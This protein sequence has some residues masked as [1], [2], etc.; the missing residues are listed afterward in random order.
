MDL[1]HKFF[2]EVHEHINQC[3]L[4]STVKSPNLNWTIR[5]AIV[6]LQKL[7]PGSHQSLLLTEIIQAW[8]EDVYI[9]ADN[10]VRPRSRLGR[11]KRDPPLIGGILQAN[12]LGLDLMYMPDDFAKEKPVSA[13]LHLSTGETMGSLLLDS[14]HR[15]WLCKDLPCSLED[16]FGSLKPDENGHTPVISI[17]A[18]GVERNLSRGKSDLLMLRGVRSM[19]AV[20]GGDPAA[21][22]WIQTTLHRAQEGCSFIAAKLTMLEHDEFTCT[23]TARL[24]HPS[25]EAVLGHLVLTSHSSDLATLVKSSE[26]ALLWD[27]ELVPGQTDRSSSSIMDRQSQ[28][29]VPLYH[30]GE[31]T[32]CVVVEESAYSLATQQSTDQNISESRHVKVGEVQN[33]GKVYI[34]RDR[35]HTSLTLKDHR[36]STTL[37][38]I[39]GKLGSRRGNRSTTCMVTKHNIPIL[40]LLR[41]GSVI[42]VGAVGSTT[43]TLLCQL[44]DDTGGVGMSSDH[45]LIDG[46]QLLVRLPLP[47]SMPVARLSGKLS[48]RQACL[49][50]GRLVDPSYVI[51]RVHRLCGTVLDSTTSSSINKGCCGK[52]PLE[53]N[54]GDVVLQMR[55]WCYIDDGKS[56]LPATLSH[57]AML[58]LTGTSADKMQRQSPE[59][60]LAILHQITEYYY[61]LACIPSKGSGGHVQLDILAVNSPTVEAMSKILLQEELASEL[62]SRSM[63]T[64]A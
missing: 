44:D 19:V 33:K 64:A 52:I 62:G 47:L 38:Q 60:R 34:M 20:V 31:K 14:R 27:L 16:V 36:G 56:I 8:T 10:E 39:T 54:A 23:G 51:S 22:M 57:S 15:E 48:L 3:L 26:V 41:T 37:L 18:T 55:G 6:A 5:E 7:E 49:V 46:M 63:V 53:L 59:E 21:V 12:V 4:Q 30:I 58:A 32:R 42:V 61:L 45:F 25:S 40:S 13:K 1:L 28:T 50:Q 29:E 11:L 24:I 43:G 17:R 9:G 2:G 35:Y